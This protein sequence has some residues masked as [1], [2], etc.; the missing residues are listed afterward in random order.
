MT[1]YIPADKVTPY[2]FPAMSVLYRSVQDVTTK[3]K[4]I[5]NSSH[6]PHFVFLIYLQDELRDLAKEV[7][8]H[9]NKHAGVSAYLEVYNKLHVAVKEV[10]QDRRMKRKIQVSLAKKKKNRLKFFVIDILLLFR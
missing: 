2:L 8:D 1:S 6:L 4:E 10:R 3:G 5:G 9:L 7:M